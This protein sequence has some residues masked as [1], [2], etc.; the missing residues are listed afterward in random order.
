M[1][2]ITKDLTYSQ[3]TGNINDSEHCSNDFPRKPTVVGVIKKKKKRAGGNV[4]GITWKKNGGKSVS[5][6]QTIQT[7]L[8][9]AKE[10]E[11]IL[12]PMGSH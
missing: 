2:Y 10:F 8:D 1:D 3:T 6:G 9:D 4:V 11:F 7:L 5:R 12:K